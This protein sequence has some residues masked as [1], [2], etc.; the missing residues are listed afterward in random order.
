MG[1]GRQTRTLAM[2]L[3]TESAVDRSSTV[4]W[5]SHAAMSWM[6]VAPR[7][8][9]ARLQ[10]HNARRRKKGDSVS[11]PV[12]SASAVRKSSAGSAS[13]RRGSATSPLG[14]GGL[15]P[16]DL[17][18]GLTPNGSVILTG[19]RAGSLP[20][21]AGG[22]GLDDLPQLMRGWGQLGPGFGDAGGALGGTDL[23]MQPPLL[24]TLAALGSTRSA[25]DAT[26][27][28]GVVRPRRL[29]FDSSRTSSYDVVGANGGLVFP[30]LA[31]PLAAPAG[32]PLEKPGCAGVDGPGGADAFPPGVDGGSGCAGRALTDQRVFVTEGARNPSTQSTSSVFEPVNNTA[33]LDAILTHGPSGG[34]G[35]PEQAAAAGGDGSARDAAK[36]PSVLDEARGLLSF[37]GYQQPYSSDQQ[38]VRCSAKCALL[39]VDSALA[40]FVHRRCNLSP[41]RR[42]DVPNAGF[43]ICAACLPRGPFLVPD[44]LMRSHGVAIMKPFVVSGTA[45]CSIARRRSCRR[46]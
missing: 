36:V 24:G 10:R 7:S 41:C 22:G 6:F 12:K 2:R 26:S 29:S 37:G 19:G 39:L 8:C 32:G 34:A 13:S 42:P 43:L 4:R 9:R 3:S 23:L 16:S 31:G 35:A 18:A 33:Q 40:S 46:T 14:G 25:G 17:I 30:G 44:A 1:T 5:S 11:P 27:P 28:P 20:L 38:L 21:M 45:G 15:S